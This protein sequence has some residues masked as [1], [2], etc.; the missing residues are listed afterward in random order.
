MQL[1]R[2]LGT[3]GSHGGTPRSTH[4][5]VKIDGCE[6]QLDEIKAKFDGLILKDSKKP[7]DSKGSHGDVTKTYKDHSGCTVS[8]VRFN[9]C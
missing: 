6:K 2:V 3:S 7:K 9:L 5:A 8:L 1:E 4:D